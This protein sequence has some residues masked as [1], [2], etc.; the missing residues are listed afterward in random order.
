VILGFAN[1]KT[2]NNIL[3]ETIVILVFSWQSEDMKAIE[4]LAI[5]PEIKL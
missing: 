4:F 3:I 2:D 1:T 5:L